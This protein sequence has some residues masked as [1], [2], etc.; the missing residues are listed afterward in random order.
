MTFA[1][2]RIDDESGAVALLGEIARNDQSTEVRKQAVFWLGRMD[3]P[4]AMQILG[5]LLRPQP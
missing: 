2:S 5:D 1:L 4:E 3:T